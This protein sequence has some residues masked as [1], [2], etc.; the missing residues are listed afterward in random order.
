MLNMNPHILT[1]FSQTSYKTINYRN[2]SLP[3]TTKDKH[4]NQKISSFFNLSLK[5]K[6]S[7]EDD[8]KNNQNFIVFMDNLLKKDEAN[9][10]ISSIHSNK[11]FFEKE[12]FTFNIN[13]CNSKK[14]INNFYL[15]RNKKK[16][17]LLN[18]NYTENKENED[19]KKSEIDR[20]SVGSECNIINYFKD[21]KNRNSRNDTFRKDNSILGSNTTSQNIQTFSLQEFDGKML[22]LKQKKYFKK[23]AKIPKKNKKISSYNCIRKILPKTLIPKI[24]FQSNNII[25]KE[26]ENKIRLLAMKENAILF[27]KDK[28]N[29]MTK[30][31]DIKNS[32]NSYGYTNE[33]KNITIKKKH[34][35]NISKFPLIKLRIFYKDKN[36]MKHMNNY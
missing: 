28:N 22:I 19:F 20:K 25:K 8:T 13:N 12:K 30:N 16:I 6:N 3:F 11:F 31:S 29:K 15:S 7:D 32:I 10:E 26:K 35:N 36:L 24:V 4:L 1:Q 14:N 34:L 17:N 2:R 5:N 27:L 33:K 23:L 9:N 18:K 21:R